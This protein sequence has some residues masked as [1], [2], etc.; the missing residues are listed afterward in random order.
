MANLF[1]TIAGINGLLVVS[2]GAFGAHALK[3]TV[4]SESF[5]T[6]QTGVLYHMVHTLALLCLSILITK[7]KDISILNASGWFFTIGIVFFSGSLYLLGISGIK[8]LGAVAPIGGVSFLCGWACLI[9]FSIKA[10]I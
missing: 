10:R 8:T 9:R 7:F 6:F 1:M 5:A 2:I 4:T 3:S